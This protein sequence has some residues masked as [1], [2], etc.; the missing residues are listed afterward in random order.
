MEPDPQKLTRLALATTH[1]CTLRMVLVE[2]VETVV[3][4]WAWFA[5]VNRSLL[6][7]FCEVY[8]FLVDH[9]DTTEPVRVTEGVRCELM[10]MVALRPM[11]YANMA[12]PWSPQVIMTDASYLSGGVV[13]TEATVEEMRLQAK[14]MTVKES[15]SVQ[16]EAEAAEQ[17]MVWEEDLDLTFQKLQHRNI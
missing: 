5:L 3:G 4:T 15:M 1:L 6:A 8:K 12:T 7:V 13:G 14:S 17:A 2:W 16:E 9:R 10:C 11:F